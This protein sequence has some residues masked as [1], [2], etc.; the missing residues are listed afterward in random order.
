[1]FFETSMRIDSHHHLWR[2]D[3][4]AFDWIP[5][6]MPELRRDFLLPELEKEIR[7]A[8]VDGSI[9]VQARQ[10][11]E[12]TTW[13]LETASGSSIY[14]VVGWAPIAAP[15]FPDVLDTL[16]RN[17]L[18]KGLRHIVQA[19]PE[20]FLLRPEFQQG[21]RAMQ[22]CGLVYE[23]LLYAPQLPEAIRFVDLHPDQPFV[24]DHGGKPRIASGEIE[25]WRRDLRKL[26]TRPNVV[27]KVS[28]LV[29]EADADDWTPGQLGAY[30]EEMLE[31]FG[32]ER[33]MIG[34]DWPVCTSRCSYKDWWA[35]VEDWVRP[36]SLSEQT[37]ILGGNAVCVYNLISGLTAQG[38]RRTAGEQH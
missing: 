1:M 33:L 23:L 14:G 20:G 30:F 2:Y 37:Q 32:A 11:L 9:V 4:V 19:E 18:L 13:L 6:G 17:P 28:G 15:E 8:L 27:C 3:P 36:L 22:G 34:T 12:E 29:T 10:I 7:Q 24:L 26:A 16:R 31:S 21:I 25:T 35:I 38:N 5:D